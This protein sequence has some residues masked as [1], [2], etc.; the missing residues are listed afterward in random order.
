MGGRAQSLSRIVVRLA[1]W[2]GG[3]LYF[4]LYLSPGEACHERIDLSQAAIRPESRTG[5][6]P[7]PHK[8]SGH[9][10]LCSC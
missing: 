5:Y 4:A 10:H 8:S 6:A 3:W 1:I 7:P 9:S 2:V